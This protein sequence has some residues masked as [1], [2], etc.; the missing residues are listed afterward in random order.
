MRQWPHLNCE[1]AAATAGTTA[2]TSALSLESFIA[3]NTRVTTALN[4]IQAKIDSILDI[5]TCPC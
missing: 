5:A 2:A 4:T 3:Y 1:T